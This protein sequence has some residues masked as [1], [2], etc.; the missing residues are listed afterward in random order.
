MKKGI[1]MAHY[2]DGRTHEG[3]GYGAVTRTGGHMKEIDMAQLLGRV[4]T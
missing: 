4:D 1:D 3:D 2:S